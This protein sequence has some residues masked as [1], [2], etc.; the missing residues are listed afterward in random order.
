MFYIQISLKLSNFE[1]EKSIIGNIEYDFE[2]YINRINDESHEILNL[3][4]EPKSLCELSNGNLLIASGKPK[5]FQ[6][7]NSKYEKIKN[8]T[9]INK[10]SFT[11]RYVT[12]DGKKSIYFTEIKNRV[13]QTDLEINFT[14]QFGGVQGSSNT[15]LNFP[16]GIAYFDSSIYI[17]DNKNKRIQKLSKDLVFQESFPLSFTPREI[18][19][20]KNV[21]CIQANSFVSLYNLQPFYHKTHIFEYT[22]Y[23][24]AS[25]PW[26]Y[27]FQTTH[28]N[29]LITCFDS[30]GNFIEKRNLVSS[31]SHFNGENICLFNNRLIIG[32]RDIKKIIIL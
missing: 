10:H 4:V 20:I 21:A 1:V 31:I 6:L 3:D 26:F 14:K 18:Q 2:N 23:I 19:V 12:T 29:T 9:K 11:P 22:A 28:D 13:I 7:L 17:C 32:V 27:S 30:N 8:I 25:N 5:C 24:F 16:C 15:Q